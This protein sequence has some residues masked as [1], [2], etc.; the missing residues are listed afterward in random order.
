MDEF[1]PGITYLNILKYIEYILKL[2]FRSHERPKGYDS[3]RP[4]KP[5]FK[6][7]TSLFGFFVYTHGLILGLK[8]EVVFIFGLG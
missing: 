6:L 5:R 8:F 3:S 1:Y 2:S 7:E 4:G